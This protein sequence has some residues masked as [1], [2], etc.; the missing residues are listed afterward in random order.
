MRLGEQAAARLDEGGEFAQSGSDFSP[1]TGQ[2][3]LAREIGEAIE[4]GESLVAEAGTGIGKTLAYLVPIMGCNKRAIISTA[5]RTLQEQLYQHDL[6]RVSQVLGRARD[7]AVLKGRDNYLCRERWLRQGNDW[8]G[9]GDVGVDDTTLT[10][11]VTSTETGDLAELPSKG[12]QAGLRRMLTVSAEACIGADCPEYAR[13]HV[14]AARARA[15]AADVVI[16][17]HHLLLADLCL[18]QEGAQG[19]LGPAEVIVVD[20]AHALPDIARDILGDSLSRAQLQELMDDAAQQFGADEAVREAIL[21]LS[22]ALRLQG[23]PPGTGKHAW[24]EVVR[25]LSTDLEA[26]RAALSELETGLAALPESET[27]VAR[28]QVCLLRLKALTMEQAD[29]EGGNF[30]WFESGEKGAFS[31]HASPLEPGGTLGDWI[32][33]S[34]A[35]WIMTSASLAVAGSFDSFVRQIGL[36]NYR[37]VLEGSPFDYPNQ[38][39]LCL[40]TGLPDVSSSVYTK[41]VV[42]ASEPLLRALNGGAFLLFTSHRALREAASLLRELGLPN[43][44]FV[45]GEGTQGRLLERFREAGNGILCGTA[46]FWKGVDVKGSALELVVIDRLPFKWQGDPLFK[47]R[48]DHCDRSGGASFPDIQI[49]EAVLAL[50]QGAGRLIRDSKDR[51]VLMICDPRLQ[52]A[53][54]RSRFLESLPPMRRTNSTAEAADFLSWRTEHECSGV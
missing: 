10:A 35:S 23:R 47:A 14:Y 27:L 6:P 18:K 8:V 44:L 41:A 49:P 9:F 38:A 40:P 42:E 39:L 26:L 48:L 3:R 34:G 17:N 19:L 4:A 7:V 11:W 32:R 31:I 15:Q 45:Q 52:T 50:K 53:R 24:Q 43:P 46:S 13:C 2:I 16:V 12:G 36:D 28:A 21:A 33:E 22:N 51:G 1:R 5:T 29:G 30:R 25:R 37:S 20:E 54:Y